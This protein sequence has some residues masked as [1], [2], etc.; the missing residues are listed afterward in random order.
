M[1][2]FCSLEVDI[3]AIRTRYP[4]TLRDL[5]HEEQE[6]ARLEDD[7]LVVREAERIRI[8]PRSPT[9]TGTSGGGRTA[10]APG[11]SGRRRYCCCW[12]RSSW[13]AP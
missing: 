5:T 11:G 9:T 7:G 12:R 1:A 10:P 4:G 3:G 2:L 13:S 8:T 6:L